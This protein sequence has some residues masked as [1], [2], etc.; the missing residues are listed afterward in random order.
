SSGSSRKASR[1]RRSTGGTGRG[2]G[3]WPKGTKKSDFGNADSG[4]GLPPRLKERSRLGVEVRLGEGLD[5]EMEE[6]KEESSD[7]DEGI[8]Y[9][10]PGMSRRRNGGANGKGKGKMVISDEEDF[11]VGDVEVD[12]EGEDE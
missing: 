6:G 4:P 10:T 5:E 8:L 12:A 7:D 9:E 3:R 11:V 2:P 1:S